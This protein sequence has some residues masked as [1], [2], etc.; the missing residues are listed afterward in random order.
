MTYNPDGKAIIARSNEISDLRKT[1]PEKAYFGC[2]TDITIP[3]E[4]LAGIWAV[5]ASREEIPV[6]EDGL[7]AVPGTED[8]NAPLLALTKK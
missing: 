3:F 7:F 4:E 8:L 5:T 2:H 1:S 6:I